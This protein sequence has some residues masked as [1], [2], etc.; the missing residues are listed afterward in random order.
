MLILLINL[1]AVFVFEQ[2]FYFL[3]S[4]RLNYLA[5]LVLI[6][7][8]AVPV[9]LNTVLYFVFRKKISPKRLWPML[10][11][12]LVLG[13]LYIYLRSHHIVNVIT[14]SLQIML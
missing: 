1:V 12:G 14:N 13:Y 4:L 6:L 2:L 10:I 7:L 11:L 5:S 3:A 8:V 9:I